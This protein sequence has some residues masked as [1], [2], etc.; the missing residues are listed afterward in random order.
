MRRT[1]SKMPQGA[2]SPMPILF[3]NKWTYR[4][5][6]RRSE[7]GLY[8]SFLSSSGNSSNSS[9]SNGVLAS[10]AD[11]RHGNHPQGNQELLVVRDN[12]GRPKVSL[13]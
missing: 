10:K 8:S 5:I 13:A 1:L 3:L 4:H 12:V 9:S 6:L 11:E 2:V 7:R